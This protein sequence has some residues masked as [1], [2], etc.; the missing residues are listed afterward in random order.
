MLI[1]NSESPL[2]QESLIYRPFKYPVFEEL[3][4]KH[5]KVHWV[6]DEI[7]MS[8]DVADWRLN[9][10]DDE[11][12]FIKQNLTIFTTGDVAVAQQY[13]K[14]FIPVFKNN[15]ANN[16]FTSVANRES[17]HQAAYAMANDTFGLPESLFSKFTEYTEMKNR[18]EYMITQYDV[19]T[20]EGL[21]LALAHTTFNEGVALFGAFI[22]LLNFNR[23]DVDGY[24]GKRGRYRGFTKI[25]KWSLRD[26]GIHVE[27]STFGFKQVLKE[28]R[29]IIND[30]FKKQ[31]YDMARQFL[32]L[33]DTYLDLVFAEYNLFTISKDDVKAYMRM[34]LD[35]RLVQLGFK[36]ITGVKTNAC[37]WVDILLGGAG[38]NTL[39]NFFET[40]VDAYQVSGALVG[41][42][43]WDI[44]TK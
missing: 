29:Q 40:R 2:F 20:V 6:T 28:H 38:G 43:N 11:K 35:R 17:E 5:E 30:E 14:L 37:E 22:S 31:V 16:W 1:Q 25:N 15:E 39:S 13:K 7:E 42:I 8:D 12:A 18:V 32:K 24:K 34:M 36:P 23:T 44:V 26:E 33:E 10:S 19:A 41:D 4:I 9:S 27:G 3:R 21:A